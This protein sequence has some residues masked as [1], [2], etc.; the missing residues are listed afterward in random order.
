[1]P[2]ENLSVWPNGHHTVTTSFVAGH[3]RCKHWTSFVFVFSAA[4]VHAIR[5]DVQ[6]GYRILLSDRL[7]RHIFITL[8]L[9]KHWS[10]MLL[11]LHGVCL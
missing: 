4:D 2:T 11:G 5:S 10:I 1:M 8:H 6:S 9:Y 7:H 3:C